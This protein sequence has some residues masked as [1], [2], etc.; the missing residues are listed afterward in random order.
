MKTLL[1]ILF[2]M[3]TV[4]LIVLCVL[5]LFKDDEKNVGSITVSP[6]TGRIRTFGDRNASDIRVFEYREVK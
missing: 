6:G 2:W 3:V 4:A 1:P 5:F